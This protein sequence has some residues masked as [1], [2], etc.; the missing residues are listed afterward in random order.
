MTSLR[1]TILQY[2]ATNGTGNPAAIQSTDRLCEFLLSAGKERDA[3]IHRVNSTLR[4]GENR[5]VSSGAA[6]T[7]W[8]GRKIKRQMDAELREEERTER[9]SFFQNNVQNEWRVRA[10]QLRLELASRYDAFRIA[11][12]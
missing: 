10:E 4:S 8:I 7:S 5:L 11:L 3:C 2:H 12:G 6:Y 1:Q 9:V